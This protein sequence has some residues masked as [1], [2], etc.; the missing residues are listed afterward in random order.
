MEAV[1]ARV[2]ETERALGGTALAFAEERRDDG[3]DRQAGEG[4]L[5]TAG[6]SA[7]SEADADDAMRSDDEAEGAAGYAA[8]APADEPPAAATRRAAPPALSQQQVDDMLALAPDEQQRRIADMVAGL[9]ARLEANPDDVDGWMILARSQVVL[10]DEDAAETAL[11]NAIRYGPE[12]VDAQIAYARIVL[13]DQ[14]LDAPV[15]PEAVAAFTR[16]IEQDPT[17]PDALWFLGLAAAQ[18]RDFATART[19]WQRLLDTLDPESEAY[20]DVQSYIA[21]LSAV[22]QEASEPATSAAPVDSTN[23]ADPPAALQ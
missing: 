18:Q 10:G 8:A 20:R 13:Q 21:A 9:A 3:T 15:P 2:A 4:G 19:H 12:R 22:G 5:A 1:R 17:H 14:P 11:E 6:A 23:A 7:A 16:V